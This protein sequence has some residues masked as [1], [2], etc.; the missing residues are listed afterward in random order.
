MKKLEGFDEFKWIQEET[1]CIDF[2]NWKGSYV[3]NLIPHRYEHFCKIMHPIYR[4]SNI[5]DENLLWSQCDP[6]EPVHFQFGERLTLKDLAEKYNIHYTKEILCSTIFHL[7]GGYPRYLI[8]PD[9]GNM[10]KE[11]L[12]EL[13]SVLYPYTK[14]KNCFFQYDLLKNINSFYEANS[15]EHLYYGKLE[16]VFELYKMGDPLELGSPSYWWAEDRSWCLHT[17]YDFD[18]SIIGGSKELITTL[19]TSNKLECIEVDRSTRVDYR[20]DKENNNYKPIENAD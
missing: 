19:L 2:T 13:I 14:G 15:N 17:N 8:L 11:T 12:Q 1:E 4:D 20:A 16:N 5:Q 18:F 7:L 3:S 10:D 9:E 6:S